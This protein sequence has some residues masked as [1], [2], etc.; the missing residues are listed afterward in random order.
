MIRAILEAGFVFWG[1]FA[2]FAVIL[3]GY[4]VWMWWTEREEPRR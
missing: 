4:L 3:V 1:L 2:A